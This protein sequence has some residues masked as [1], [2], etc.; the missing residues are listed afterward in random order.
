[1]ALNTSHFALL[2]RHGF[3]GGDSDVSTGLVTM[4][5][6]SPLPLGQ[7]LT[8]PGLWLGLA[9]TALFLYLAVKLR[10]VRGLI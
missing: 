6:L 5:M 7:F 4:D 1:M 3:M 8:A 2:M 10:R 9:V